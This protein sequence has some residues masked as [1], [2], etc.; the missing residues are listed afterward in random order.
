MKKFFLLTVVVLGLVLGVPAIVGFKVEDR[1]QLVIDRAQQR[2]LNIKAHDY[3]RGWFSSSATTR[4]LLTRP[5]QGAQSGDP[6]SL[7]LTLDS[8][9]AHGP[10]IS[11]GLGLAEI[12]SAI[13]FGERAVFPPDYP[14]R[15]HTLVEFAG[16]GVTE[17]ELPA[18][19]IPASTDLPGIS[20]G[21]LSA[22]I[23]F[24]ADRGGLDINLTAKGLQLGDGDKKL[25]ELGELLLKSNTSTSASGLLLGTGEFTLQRFYVRDVETGG[26]VTISGI[27]V[28]VQSSEE[29]EQVR[30]AA[31]YHVESITAGDK[32][33][34]PGKLKVELGQLSAPVM[35]RLQQAL[36]EINGKVMPDTERG[37]AL[38]GV[39]MSIAPE[40]LKTDPFISIKPLQ[41]VTPDGTV[42][43]EIMLRGDG[44]AL[45]DLSN[46]QSLTGKLVADLSLRMPEKLLRAMLIQ[47]TRLKLEQQM[48]FVAEQG[49]EVP[50]LDQAQLQQLVELRVDEQIDQWLLQEVVERDG[51]DLA[52]VVSLSSGLLTVNGKTIPLP[53]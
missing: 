3:Q 36:E 39:M 46:L 43:G 20:F 13:K 38:M 17:I 45:A 33:Y 9:I 27:A 10:L 14:A 28:D 32:R 1:Y 51:E 48:K 11:S 5:G 8:V 23:S 18:S 21:G 2:G 42:D 24:A 15:M 6:K 31:N 49:G 50:D 37:M 40:L 52:T 22:R 34:G 26:Q 19:E 4:F 29:S 53:F 41:L 25:V 44:L 35:V 30:A 12:D 16:N 7:E 47:Q